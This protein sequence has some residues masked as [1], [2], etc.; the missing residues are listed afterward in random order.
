LINGT[1]RKGNPVATPKLEK[2]DSNLLIPNVAPR[3]LHHITVFM[4]K[5]EQKLRFFIFIPSVSRFIFTVINFK[6]KM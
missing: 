4:L 1:S 5:F 3:I 6:V 2:L